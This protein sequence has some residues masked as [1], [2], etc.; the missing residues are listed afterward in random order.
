M[1]TNS[2]RRRTLLSA[3]VLPLA[4]PALG[5]EVFPSR[6]LRLI[7]GFTPGGATD[8]SARA[9]APKMGEALGQP[10]I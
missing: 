1:K 10:V 7:V 4:A 2:F 8:I 3:D 6:P 5:Q 9:I